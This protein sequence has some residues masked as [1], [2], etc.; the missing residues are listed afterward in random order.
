M[1]GTQEK[2]MKGTPLSKVFPSKSYYDK[3]SIANKRIFTTNQDVFD[4]FW[5]QLRSFN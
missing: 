1:N 2:F 4:Q 3:P 5:C